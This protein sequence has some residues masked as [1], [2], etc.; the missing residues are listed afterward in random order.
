MYLRYR[1]QDC[2]LTLRGGIAEYR[3]YFTVIGRE[4]MVDHASSRLI[5]EH[6][7]AHVI[8]GMDT[9]LQQKAGIDT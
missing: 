4:A 8:F 9:S 3:A 7:A 5:L 1:E 2:G 6:D